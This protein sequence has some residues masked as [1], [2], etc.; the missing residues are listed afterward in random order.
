MPIRSSQTSSAAENAGR[1]VELIRSMGSVAVAFSAGVDSTVVAK[2]AALAV[3][4]QAVASNDPQT[5]YY[6]IQPSELQPSLDDL[7]EQFRQPQQRFMAQLL[8]NDDARDLVRGFYQS[9]DQRTG[10][11]FNTASNE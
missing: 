2:A 10:F 6:V 8:G 1:V 5:V 7:K 3:G 11:E 4:E 9:V